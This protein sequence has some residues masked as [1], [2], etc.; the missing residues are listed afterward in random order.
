MEQ[1]TAASLS[2]LEDIPGLEKD[3]LSFGLAA[4]EPSFEAIS[5]DQV[6][7]KVYVPAWEGLVA[8]KRTAIGSSTVRDIPR[9]LRDPE[10]FGQGYAA[11]TEEDERNLAIR[12]LGAAFALALF[13]AGWR[14]KVEFG[15]A[16]RFESGDS[17]IHALDLVTGVST[18]EV[19]LE[20][21]QQ[22][23]EAAG[24][25]DLRLC[26]T[27]PKPSQRTRQRK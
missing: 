25:A 23:I 13:Q 6:G 17:Q 18:G 20:A 10:Q 3:L 5:W 11:E 14:L 24:I 7:E 4:D 9:K 19:T 1:E 21:F 8:E 15:E 22:Q 2:L 12:T 26:C 16:I 27:T